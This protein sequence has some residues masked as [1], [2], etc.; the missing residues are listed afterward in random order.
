MDLAAI[1]PPQQDLYSSWPVRKSTGW[2]PNPNLRWGDFFTER[3]QQSP[4]RVTEL[5]SS[6]K[7]VRS[8][9]AQ[10]DFVQ[11]TPSGQRATVSVRSELR[12]EKDDQGWSISVGGFLG[13]LLE[14]HL[15]PVMELSS[16]TGA[17]DW[18]DERGVE[19][20]GF[21]LADLDEWPRREI[22]V[23]LA[24][25]RSGERWRIRQAKPPMASKSVHPWLQPLWLEFLDAS[26]RP[27]GFLEQSTSTVGKVWLRKDLGP[28]QALVLA[29]ICNSLLGRPS[30]SLPAL[31]K[32]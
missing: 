15:N 20:W 2:L 23:G 29:S 16:I 19:H 12:N 10:V 4:S 18:S 8:A 31:D 5:T 21:Y 22:D 6:P 28:N 3:W 24:A 26:G 1:E 30:L 7:L 32:P 25:S 17:I 11:V 27:L 9:R 14:D 13:Q